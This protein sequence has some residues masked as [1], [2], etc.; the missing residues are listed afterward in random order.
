MPEVLSGGQIE[1]IGVPLRYQAEA[2]RT[3]EIYLPR[4][5]VN[6]VG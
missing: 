4:P 1:G 2:M 3:S 5:R 6:S